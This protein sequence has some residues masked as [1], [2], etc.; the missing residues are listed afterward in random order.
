MDDLLN[1]VKDGGTVV[2][3]YNINFD[4]GKEKLSPYPFK[5]SRDRV[6]EE[7][8]EVRIL[9]PDHPVLNTP[10]KIIPK[11]FEG[12]VQERGLYF[13]SEWDPAFEAIFSMNDKKEAPKDGSLLIAKYG[14]GY[15]VYTGISFFRQLPAGVSG[16]YKL[17]ANLIS[18]SKGKSVSTLNGQGNQKSQK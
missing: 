2:M 17:F 8:A 14:K 4:F 9:K 1:Y 7:N 15:F 10:N 18:L 6:T 5:L 16:A 13:A 11:D 3:Q 12:W